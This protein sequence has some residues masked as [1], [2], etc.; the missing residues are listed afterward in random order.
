MHSSTP[1]GTSPH[2]H[3]PDDGEQPRNAWDQLTPE[4]A[5]AFLNDH[6]AIGTKAFWFAASTRFLLAHLRHSL[7]YW[8][9]VKI[10]LERAYLKPWN[11]EQWIDIELEENPDLA[12]V[13]SAFQAQT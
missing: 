13:G 3:T 9:A 10:L 8:P 11:Y 12:P 2:A 5:Y 7:R 4:D 1:N 6:P